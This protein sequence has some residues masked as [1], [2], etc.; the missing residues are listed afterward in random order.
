MTS[1][2][3]GT[4]SPIFRMQ[5]E[6]LMSVQPVQVA[7]CLGMRLPHLLIVQII[8]CV[9]T[10]SSDDGYPNTKPLRASAHT[11]RL[12]G[13]NIVA[14]CYNVSM[15][16][17]IIFDKSWPACNY[18]WMI[19]HFTIHLI[20]H[21]IFSRIKVYTMWRNWS[22]NDHFLL[23]KACRRPFNNTGTFSLEASTA[24]S[25]LSKVFQ[26]NWP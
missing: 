3:P 15:K 11:T 14:F 17:Q 19:S 6:T 9:R 22:D 21:S 26:P 10:S 13:L 7:V 4:R 8:H 5:L 25:T 24:T 16:H 18:S 23:A 2:G 20:W 12:W 1:D